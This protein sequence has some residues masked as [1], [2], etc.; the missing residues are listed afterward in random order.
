MKKKEVT[1]REKFD[2]I[3]KA[4]DNK[5]DDIDYENIVDVDA[6]GENGEAES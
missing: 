4:A 1:V 2:E 3:E 6:D 5:G